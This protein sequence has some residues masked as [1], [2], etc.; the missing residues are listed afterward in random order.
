MGVH[1]Q[2]FKG[3]KCEGKGRIFQLH[4]PIYPS[5][6]KPRPWTLAL[7]RS[8]LAIYLSSILGMPGRVCLHYL[9]D[10]RFSCQHSKRLRR[11]GTIS[12]LV[13]LSLLFSPASSAFVLTER[14][15]YLVLDWTDSFILHLPFFSLE[16]TWVVYS[17]IHPGM[18]C[19]NT[20]TVLKP[21]IKT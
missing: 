8:W 6:S 19:P 16:A 1:V 21:K 10:G 7:G 5:V 18:L 17:S 11:A 2:D 20:F 9:L 15:V 12:G 14:V 13:V 3:A 4:N